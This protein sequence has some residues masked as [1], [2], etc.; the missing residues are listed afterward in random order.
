MAGLLASNIDDYSKF[1]VGLILV[2]FPDWEPFSCVQ[3]DI[4]SVFVDFYIPCP[5]LAVERGLW[6]STAN[7]ELTVGFHTDHNHFTDYDDPLN[8]EP[9]EAGLNQAAAY[10]E[11]RCGAVS[12][13]QGERLAGTTSAELPLSGLIPRVFKDYHV[14]LGT[15]RSWSGQYDRDEPC[16]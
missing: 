1:A 5:S 16:A 15:L 9:V 14:T 13:Y 3:S 7:Q 8:P 6:V 12:W 4:N 2:R 11:D 10:L